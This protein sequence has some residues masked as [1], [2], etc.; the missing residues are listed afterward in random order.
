MRRNRK[1]VTRLVQ[2]AKK[3][4]RTARPFFPAYRSVKMALGAKLIMP[5]QLGGKTMMRLLFACLITLALPSA[6]QAQDDWFCAYQSPTTGQGLDQLRVEGMRLK[7]MSPDS[8]LRMYLPEDSPGFFGKGAQI[9]IDNELALMAHDDAATT[10]R[11]G[12]TQIYS[13]S[14]YIEKQ[15]GAFWRLEWLVNDRVGA[16]I[17]MT[18]RCVQTAR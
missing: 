16:P 4:E 10:T 14:V 15:T 17:H 2:Q 5:K 18:G 6:G 3:W 1:G 9:L 8:L 13:I 11:E 7:N 12:A